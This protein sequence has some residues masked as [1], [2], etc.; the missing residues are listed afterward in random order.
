MKWRISF[1]L[2]LFTD[3][4][5]PRVY[6]LLK[7]SVTYRN[8]E[9]LE[10]IS[11]YQANV[12]DVSYRSHSERT[13]SKKHA[14]IIR[15]A[16]MFRVTL[17]QPNLKPICLFSPSFSRFICHVL[18]VSCVSSKSWE[19]S[20][21]KTMELFTFILHAIFTKLSKLWQVS[22]DIPICP[23]SSTSKYYKVTEFFTQVLH[24]KNS[25][26]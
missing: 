24:L 7:G 12:L 10:L 21:V 1:V 14:S 3:L 5:C 2:W 4:W 18:I 23:S 26:G 19:T 9:Q 25:C 17:N 22:M 15:E 6:L 16:D 13:S 20:K 8:T 11:I